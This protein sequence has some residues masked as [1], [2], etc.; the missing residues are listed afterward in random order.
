MLKV[1]VISGL[2]GS[3]KSTVADGT[4]KRLSLPVFSID[5]IEAALWRSGLSK[6]ETGIAAYKV[7][8]A[9]A[10]EQLR[11]GLSVIID[12]VNPVEKARATWRT[13]AQENKATLVLIEIICSDEELHKKRIESRVRNIDGMP[14]VNWDRV[15]ER[16]REYEPWDED[17]L[18]LDSVEESDKLI[19]K[20]VEYISKASS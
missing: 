11:L 14:E 13:L 10:N 9:E 17:R 15:L 12:A 1:I 4:A 6:K 5:P 8:D 20:T 19:E 7:A 3:G 2:P 16:K 18:I